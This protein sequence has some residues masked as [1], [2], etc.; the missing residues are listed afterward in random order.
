MFLQIPLTGKNLNFSWLSHLV[1]SYSWYERKNTNI[2]FTTST[3]WYSLDRC[4]Q[5]TFL[6][7]I[8]FLNVN[9][10]LNM[11]QILSKF[12]TPNSE[13]KISIHGNIILLSVD[14]K[15][16]TYTLWNI[17]LIIHFWKYLYVIYLRMYVKWWWVYKDTFS[18]PD[19]HQG[20]IS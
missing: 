9:V 2:L 14:E 17:H 5:F 20:T 11:N 4:V 18:I 6:E 12:A 3:G 15:A 19:S 1:C 13:H 7:M 10:A 16:K 8:S